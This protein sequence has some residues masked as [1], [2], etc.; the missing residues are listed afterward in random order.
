MPGG[1]VVT[2]TASAMGPGG[3]GPRRVSS[4][5]V[6]S[7]SRSLQNISWK[8]S[9]LDTGDNGCRISSFTDWPAGGFVVDR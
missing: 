6:V 8:P 1:A 7:S 2:V 4:H 9:S 3:S 5:E